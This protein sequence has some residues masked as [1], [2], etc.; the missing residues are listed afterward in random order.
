MV[1]QDYTNKKNGMFEIQTFRFFLFQYRLF[2][3]HFCF[4]FSPVHELFFGLGF[5]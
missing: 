1:G 2:L 5:I 3:N 4:K